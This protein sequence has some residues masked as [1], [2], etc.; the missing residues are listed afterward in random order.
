MPLHDCIDHGKKGN[1]RGYIAK[2][3]K[4]DGRHTSTSY[5]RWVYTQ[6]HD[7]PLSSLDGL[8]VRHKC[9][10]PRCINPEHLELGTVQDNI[11]DRVKRGRGNNPA[12]ADSHRAKLTAE[13]VAQIRAAY[14][15]R[16]KLFGGRALAKLYGVAPSVISM[17]IGDKQYVGIR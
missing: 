10:N 7:V 9:D 6:H 1:S 3:V 17:I 11:D 13:E 8:V 14:I 15:P 12:G 5:I 16:H 4:V 2:S